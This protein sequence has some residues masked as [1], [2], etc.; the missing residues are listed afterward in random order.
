MKKEE[1]FEGIL[2]SSEEEQ[3]DTVKEIAKNTKDLG[4]V[5]NDSKK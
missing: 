4:V 2:S 5:K 1:E 3:A